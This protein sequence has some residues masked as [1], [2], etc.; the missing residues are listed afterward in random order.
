MAT[1]TERLKELRQKN[2]LTQKELADILGVSQG[3]YANWENGKRKPDYL[4]ISDIAIYF[5][6]SIDYLTGKIDKEYGEITSQVLESMSHDEIEQ[7]MKNALSSI[8][9][10]LEVGRLKGIPKTEMLK[11]FQK[12]QPDNIPIL[13]ILIDKVYSSSPNNNSTTK[14][15]NNTK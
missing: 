4:Q 14:Q 5:N 13:E 11:I 10:T 15:S 12:E 2:N 6:T 3:S 8:L 7:N 9:T 1:F